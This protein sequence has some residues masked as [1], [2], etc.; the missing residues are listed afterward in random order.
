MWEGQACVPH[1]REEAPLEGGFRERETAAIK[2]AFERRCALPGAHFVE[3]LAQ[4]LRIDE[5]KPIGLVHSGLQLVSVQA[6]SQ[7]HKRAHD[8]GDR[9]AVALSALVRGERG[10]VNADPRAL[11]PDLGG[12]CDLD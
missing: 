11:A 6:S 5:V 10:A 8:G 4:P 1:D 2:E 9:D 3:R 7:I 12:H